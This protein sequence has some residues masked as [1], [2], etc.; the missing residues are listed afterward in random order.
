[1]RNNEHM[2]L[3]RA[4]L[5]AAT[6]AAL[7]LSPTAGAAG[8]R[9]S[10]DGGTAG[11]RTQVRAALAASS[12]RWSLIPKRVTVHI[13]RG[14]VTRAGAGHVWLDADLLDAGLF[15]WGAVQHEF[16][17]EVDFLF[18]TPLQ[19]MQIAA[20]LGTDEWCATESGLPHGLY[21]CERFASTLTWSYWPSRSN[22]F[23][24]ESPDDEAAA[25]PPARFRALL[26]SV[27]GTG[28]TR[29]A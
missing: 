2:A 19:R 8:A 6:A 12:F 23:R 13:G 18:L 26:D 20:A 16:A 21:G 25:L 15:A 1:M 4:L 11:Q 5:V 9:L 24:P 3:P 22:A 10:W 17:H 29:N 27:L 28:T 14:Y 7:L